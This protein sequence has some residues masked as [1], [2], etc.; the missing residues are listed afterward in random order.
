DAVVNYLFTR[1][2]LGFFV[3][4]DLLQEEVGRSGYQRIEALDAQG[5]ASAIDRLLGLYRRGVTEAQYN[6]LGSHD[7]P[8]FK[9]LARGDN[10]AYR[11]ATLFQMTFPGAPSIYYGDEIGLEG[12][13]DPGCREGFPWDE[14][15][16][17][18]ELR[19]FVRR[20]IALRKRH[21]A[22]RR[23][24]FTWLSANQGV[25][26]YGRRLGA[27]TLL[28][29][30]NN[31]HQPLTQSLPVR[32]YVEDGTLLLDLW[33]GTQASVSHGQ[34]EGIELAARSGVVLGTT[35]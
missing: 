24:D 6:L 10:S 23:G 19:D 1:A 20:C 17:D 7:T 29:V 22:L 25:V 34:I 15:Q 21:P 26:A 31:R 30:L 11:L 28:V 3:G 35:V 27:E 4:D 8:R 12:R 32:G 16:W 33:T 5:F 9:A 14:R 2:C 18:Q 13:H